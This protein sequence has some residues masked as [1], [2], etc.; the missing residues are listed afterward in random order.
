M[1]FRKRARRVTLGKEPRRMSRTLIQDLIAGVVDR[2]FVIQPTEDVSN[3]GTGEIFENADTNS[4]VSPN[5]VCKYVNARFQLSSKN[6]S[7]QN[8]GWFE[9]AF[10]IFK[11]EEV[12]PALNTDF[13]SFGGTQTIGDIAVNLY[14]GKCIW[15]GAIPISKEVPQSVDVKIKMP[16]AHCKW[17]RGMYL[18]LISK[19]RADDATDT[20]S[21]VRFV[22]SHQFKIYS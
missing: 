7:P 11:E 14:R 5:A 12:A 21:T 18:A 17:Q 6:V 9:Y 3:S 4:V 13:T 8:A 22:Y 20:T 1:P 10:I 19:F 2:I 16:L 15:N